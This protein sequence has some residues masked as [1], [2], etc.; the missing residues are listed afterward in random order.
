MTRAASIET[1]AE[2]IGAAGAVAL[3]QEFGGLSVKVPKHPAGRVWSK[4][5]ACMGERSAA[6]L[7][8]SFGG[9]G[10]YIARNEAEARS[11][12]RAQ[13]AAMHAQGLSLSQIAKAYTYTQRYTERGIRR[14]LDGTPGSAC[15]PCRGR[16]H[17][18]PN[19]IDLLHTD[20]TSALPTPDDLQ[21]VWA[22]VVRV[23]S[24][25]TDR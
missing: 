6:D 11:Q 16:R 14:I 17:H 2:Y 13:L 8:E 19:Q 20:G 1:L 21:G 23:D 12:R 5:V 4:L 15:A 22:N 10:L 9:E 24:V 25:P 7:V 18:N 3:V